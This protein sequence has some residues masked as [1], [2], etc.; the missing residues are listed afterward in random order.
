MERPIVLET[1]E[2]LDIYINPRRQELLRI[3]QIANEPMTPKQLSRIMEISTSSVQH[4]LKKL[5]ELGVVKLH[6]TQR[7]R[8]ITAHY[9]W[10]PP[11]V[12]SLGRTPHSEGNAQRLALMQN[13]L[14]QSFDRF[15]KYFVRCESEPE[16]ALG[17][18]NWGVIRLAESEI[19]ALKQL[20][21]DFVHEHE[22]PDAKGIPIEYAMFAY[23][24]G[25]ETDA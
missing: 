3:M 2:Q 14:T 20:V 25:E 15:A 7:V 21:L 11:R 18:M 10:L 4:H 17:T 13:S 6:H 19:R 23:P 1:R 24:A 12:I 8:N 5:E 16:N 9:Y 22:K